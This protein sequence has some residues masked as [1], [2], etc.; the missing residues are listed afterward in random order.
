MAKKRLARKELKKPD[1]FITLTTKSFQ[2]VSE[3]RW[4]F[5][6]AIAAV[7]AVVVGRWGW[8]ARQVNYQVRAASQFAQ[9]TDLYSASLVSQDTVKLERAETELQSFLSTFSKGDLFDLALLYLGQAQFSLGKYDPAINSYNK[10]LQ[11]HPSQPTLIALAHNGLGHTLKAKGDYLNAAQHFAQAAQLPGSFV[12]EEA[13]LNQART[14]TSAGEPAKAQQ[15]YQQLINQFPDS[16][17][18]RLAR[19]KLA[20]DIP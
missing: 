6:I 10:L 1:E 20:G 13:L 16:P 12:R 7:L 5:V 15:A 18:A 2:F 17:L 4:L 8:H 19:Q 3:H 14:L 9:A 11:R